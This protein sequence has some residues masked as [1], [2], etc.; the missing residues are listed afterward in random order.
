MPK[1]ILIVEDNVL[2][3]EIMTCI[4]NNMGY[5]VIPLHNGYEV[6]T[7]IKT[8]HPDL[9]I[10][11]MMLPGIDGR[12]ICSLIKQNSETSNLPIIICSGNEDIDELKTQ[13]GAPDDILHKPFD[14]NALVQKVQ[15]Q[16]AA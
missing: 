12:D 4:L 10:L 7:Y 3:A 14:I 5:D 6:F 9:V 2:M 15:F 11:D 8:G 1:K 13:R 16:L